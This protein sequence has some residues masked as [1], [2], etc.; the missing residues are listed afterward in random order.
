M[1]G[2]KVDAVGFDKVTANIEEI[3]KVIQQTM[4][5]MISMA[6]EVNEIIQPI[7]VS[8]NESIENINLQLE[9]IREHISGCIEIYH[10]SMQPFIESFN[11]VKEGF[12]KVSLN[13]CRLIDKYNFEEIII[14]EDDINKGTEL[15]DYINENIDNN[16]EDG[17]IQDN[18]LGRCEE[19]ILNTQDIESRKFTL[20]TIV[21]SIGKEIVNC[22]NDNTLFTKIIIP[23]VAMISAIIPLII[24]NPSNPQYIINNSQYIEYTNINYKHEDNNN[25]LNIFKS[26]N[27]KSECS[28]IVNKDEINLM[29]IVKS[30]QEW[31]YIKFKVGI[32]HIEGW[33]MSSELN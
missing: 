18:I 28:Y 26:N 17:H 3:S 23:G 6:Q 7:V 33:V 27:I 14:N 21:D 16:I 8:M 29:E 30:E 24:N 22:K 19:I 4:E 5:P 25:K 20:K 10:Q 13:I 15:L 9:P 11:N 1:S 32:Y 12:E 2:I 31:S